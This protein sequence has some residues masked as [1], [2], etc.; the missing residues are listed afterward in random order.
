MTIADTSAWRVA[1]AF[2]ALLGLATVPVAS[3]TLPPLVDYPNH[4]ARFHLLAEGGNAYYAV[5]WAAL[6]NLG[7][8][9]IVPALSQ[10]MPLT[11]AGRLFLVLTFALLAGGAVW[12]NRV[13][14]GGWRLWPLLAFSVLYNRLLLWGFINYLFGVGLA[15]CGLALWL[16]LERAPRWRLAISPLA[17]LACFFSHIAA[18][19][20][21]ALLIAGVE[22]APAWSLARARRWRPLVRRLVEA[23]IQFVAPVAIFLSLWQPQAQG[24]GINFS[25]LARKADLLFNV[26]D[27]Y[28][29]PFD[30]A[31][32]VVLIALFG[33][34]AWRRRLHLSPRLR[35]AL[36]LLAIAY[37]A[38]PSQMFTGS[39][40]DHR[41]PLTLF[42]LLIAAASPRF[43]SQRAARIVGLAA[44]AIFIARMA[45]IETIWL[46]ADRIYAA[47]W[48]GLNV[49]PKGA[50]LAV[51]F[52]PSGIHAGAIPELHVA[53]LAVKLRDA[54]VPTMFAYPAQQPL[55]VRPPYDA[56]GDRTDPAALWAAF[57]DNDAQ[58]RERIAPVIAQYDAIVFTNIRPF[59]V[60]AQACLSPVATRPTWQLFVLDHTKGC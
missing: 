58:A 38:M 44:A 22:I 18:F 13:V 42:L 45:V 12:L 30:I 25:A 53:T 40:A 4:L 34:L 43:S 10:I 47:D 48:A 8:D 37:L 6:P 15:F 56:L 35:P 11:V 17:A 21:Y 41:L 3:T 51:A 59:N 23:G 39:G 52:P 33:W 55:R 20:V 50:R 19:G 16:Q 27:N 26:F 7:A 9:L 5:R 60:A 29:R 24:G 54:F 1:A 14:S 28:S 36:A 46:R 49:L 2:I 32:F 57:V 31:C